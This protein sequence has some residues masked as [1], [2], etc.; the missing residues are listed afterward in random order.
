MESPES[1]L[2]FMVVVVLSAIFLAIF[3]RRRYGAVGRKLIERI[4]PR[5]P[6]ILKIGSIV[7][8]VL[9]LVIWVLISPERRNELQK[10]YDENAPWVV[11]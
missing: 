1:S 3:I 11:R 2:K 10:L 4:G 5:W 7:T 9:W 6:R 8:L